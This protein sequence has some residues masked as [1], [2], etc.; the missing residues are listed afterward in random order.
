M[1]RLLIL[2]LLFLTACPEEEP[3]PSDKGRVQ[4]KLTPF[5]GSSAV[6]SAA[7]RPAILQG[8]GAAELSQKFQ[9]A[10]A[11]QLRLKQQKAALD[12]SQPDFPVIPP[13][14]GPPPLSAH[15]RGGS[16]HHR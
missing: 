2:G 7:S 5:L 13:P 12:V 16:H 10:R 4:G 8:Q 6:G 11:Q 14:P 9:R 1:R 3:L 15:A